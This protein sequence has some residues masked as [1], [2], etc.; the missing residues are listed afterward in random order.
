LILVTGVTGQSGASVIREFARQGE[1][2]RGL[3]RDRAMAHAMGLDNL[4]TVELVE[5]DMLRSETLHAAF[6]SREHAGSGLGASMMEERH[7]A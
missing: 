1:R 5:G 4:P 6:E 3:G 7:V 2:V